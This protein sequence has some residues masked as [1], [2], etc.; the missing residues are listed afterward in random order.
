MSKP[1]AYYDSEKNDGTWTLF[2]KLQINFELSPEELAIAFLCMTPEQMIKLFNEL[3]KMVYY[4][5]ESLKE[6]QSKLSQMAEAEELTQDAQDSI[7]LMND[8]LMDP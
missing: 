1:T 4:T 2:K 7:D 3:G 6:F 8:R 5:E